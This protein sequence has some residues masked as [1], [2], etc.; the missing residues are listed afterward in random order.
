MDGRMASYSM[1]D[2]VG[3][4]TGDDGMTYSFGWAD[5]LSP[6][7]NVEAGLQVCFDRIGSKAIRVYLKRAG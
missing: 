4:I 2:D 7:V 6:T 5:W 1:V 3:Y